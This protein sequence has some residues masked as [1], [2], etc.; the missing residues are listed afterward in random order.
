MDSR[1]K[2]ALE[3]ANYRQTLNNQLQELKILS[4][5]RLI[6]SKNGGS[7]IV[8][9]SLI[10]FVK[11]LID[12]GQDEVVLLDKNETPVLIDDLDGFYQ[13][14]L[15]RYFEV[16]NDY[17]AEYEKIRKSRSVKKIISFE[18]HD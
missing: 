3:F 9:Q 13:D 6:Y 14:L 11:L 4:Q 16:T 15:S 1:L 18:E 7:F 5:S 10:T 8:E 2:Q 12:E 17:Q